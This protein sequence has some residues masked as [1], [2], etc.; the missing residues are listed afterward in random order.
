[1][2][3]LEIVAQPPQ[4]DPAPP[5][6]GY[7]GWWDASDQGSIQGGIGNTAAAWRDKSGAGR[8]MTQATDANRPWTGGLTVN[9]RNVLLSSGKVSNLAGNIPLTTQPF[10][11]FLVAANVAPDAV[12]R[13]CWAGFVSAGVEWGRIYRPTSNA[14]A[15]YAGGGV[16]SSQAWLAGRV[17]V[18]SA[19]FNGASSTLNVDSRTQNTGAVGGNGNS[20]TGG[21]FGLGLSESWFGWI[22]ELIVYDARA[23]TA[24]EIQRV[25][26]YL[27]RKW[28]LA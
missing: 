4:A 22:G 15:I 3:N 17:R 23:L 26:A 16:T 1:M 27:M 24:S 8:H 20:V 2:R 5:V 25:E 13:T 9:G 6:P 10:T 19:I 12:Q 7:S 11:V 14:I 18:V 21:A 28:G